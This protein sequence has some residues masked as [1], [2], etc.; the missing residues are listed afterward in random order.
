MVKKG[1]STAELVAATARVR[2]A[3]TPKTG[4]LACKADTL[5]ILSPKECLA[6][7]KECKILAVRDQNSGPAEPIMGIPMER[8]SFAEVNDAWK[9]ADKDESRAVAR[10][11]KKDAKVVID[12]YRNRLQLF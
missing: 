9:A 12:V 5:K 6:R 8:V 1:G 2:M 10:R 7:M 3:G 4:N 11:W